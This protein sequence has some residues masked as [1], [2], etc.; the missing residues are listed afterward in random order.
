VICASP[1]SGALQQNR[2]HNKPTVRNGGPIPPCTGRLAC[3]HSR[4]NFCTAGIFPTSSFDPVAFRIGLAFRR[5]VEVDRRHDAVA[6]L[7]DQNLQG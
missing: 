2:W 3:F 7:L 6:E 4:R 1:Y 5:Q